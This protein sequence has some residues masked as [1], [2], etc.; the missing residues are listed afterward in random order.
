LVATKV[1]E[2]LK[3]NIVALCHNECR[4][5]VAPL[6]IRSAHHCDV[7]DIGVQGELAFNVLRPHFLAPRVNDIATPSFYMKTPVIS[8]KTKVASWQPAIICE[9]RT[10][11]AVAAEQHRAL[12]VNFSLS[13]VNGDTIERLSV[14]DHTAS[15]FG[16]PV[17]GN[18]MRWSVCRRACTAEHDVP[19]S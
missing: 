14:I 3:F 2:L 12:E 9:R 13:D 7:Y 4:N 6:V 1:T 17:G 8:E 15:R 10:A 5:D 11:V 19:K 18:A 16:E